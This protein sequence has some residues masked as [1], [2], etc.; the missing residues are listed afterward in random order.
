MTL[1]P[2]ALM[3]IVIVAVSG[4]IVKK[5]ITDKI[6]EELT[7]DAGLVGFIFDEYY[8]GDFKVETDPETGALE[9]YKGDQKLNG[10]GTLMQKLSDMMDIQVS[11]F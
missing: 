10:E 2:L 3:T 11:I 8:Y 1:V 6:E 4:S 5:A 9:L 7:Y